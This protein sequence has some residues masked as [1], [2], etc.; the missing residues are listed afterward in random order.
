MSFLPTKG[1]EYI[2]VLSYLALLIPFWL[3]FRHLGRAQ[4]LAVRLSR[5]PRVAAL[6]SWFRVPEHVHLHRGHGWARA[7]QQDLL[8]VGMDEFA[9]GLMGRPD[10]FELPPVGSRLQQGEK[11]WGVRID[12]HAFELLSPVSGEVVAVHERIAEQPAAA[13]VEPYDEGWLLRVRP[14]SGSTLRNLLPP[15]LGRLW[16]DQLQRGLSARIGLP[17]GAVLQDGGLPISG[18]ARQLGGD[19]WHDLVQEYLLTK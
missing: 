15:A 16:M 9:Y 6:S 11:G 5:S 13:A 3:W 4:P 7:G 18:F 2:L 10:A 14:D 19:H 12:G 8:E 1:Y 17:E